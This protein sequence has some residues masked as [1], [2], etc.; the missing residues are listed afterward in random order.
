[1]DFHLSPSEHILIV[2]ENGVGKTTLLRQ[3]AKFIRKQSLK[4]V[5]HIE[6]FPHISDK[7]LKVSEYLFNEYGMPYDNQERIHQNYFCKISDFLN[8]EVE[9]L[10]FGEKQ[11]LQISATMESN[12]DSRMCIVILDEPTTHMDKYTKKMF[13]DWVNTISLSLI[14]ST[15]DPDVIQTFNGN[16]YQLVR[17]KDESGC[18]LVRQYDV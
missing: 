6:Q 4:S 14:I 3:I 8:R 12:F 15:H 9:T 11:R 2:G 16:T 13:M 5:V 10:S 18:L 1:L 17:G 7:R